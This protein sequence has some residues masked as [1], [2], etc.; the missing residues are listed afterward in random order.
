MPSACPLLP[1]RLSTADHRRRRLRLALRLLLL[2]LRPQPHLPLRRPHARA[3]RLRAARLL[4][5]RRVLPRLRS[6][7]ASSLT[8]RQRQQRARGRHHARLHPA[9]QHALPAVGEPLA[10]VR[11]RLRRPHGAGVEVSVVASGQT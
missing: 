9:L 10:A 7:L 6:A 8:R 3:R 4:A 11:R 5:G 1:P 2:L